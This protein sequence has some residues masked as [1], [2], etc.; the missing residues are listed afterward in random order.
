MDSAQTSAA[1][2]GPMAKKKVTI[3]IVSDIF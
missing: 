1:S 2:R 3:D